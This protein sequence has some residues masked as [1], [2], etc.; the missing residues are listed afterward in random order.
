MKALWF[1]A[2]GVIA[3]SAPT[4]PWPE[5]TGA[6]VV[7]RPVQLL[8]D[9][10]PLV[11]RSFFPSGPM[12][13]SISV[14][15]G[16][17]V[18]TRWM[19]TPPGD[20][21]WML[22]GQPAEPLAVMTCWHHGQPTHLLLRRSEVRKISLSI[23]GQP[24]D[25]V[26]VRGAF[27]G[28][29]EL[30][31]PMTYASGQWRANLA[32]EPGTYEYLFKV[33][34]REMRD[35]SQPD[36]ASNG[37]GG[38]NSLLTVAGPTGEAPAELNPR[39]SADS[40]VSLPGLAPDQSWVA[41]LGNRMWLQGTG[42][43]AATALPALRGYHTLRFMTWRG[44]VM[45]AEVHLPL[46]DGVPVDQPDQLAAGDFHGLS[47]Y[48]LM[49]D[50][51]SNGDTTN[52]HPLNLPDVAPLADW[53]GG[54][55]AGLKSVV[56]SGYFDSLGVTGLW[57]SPLSA[58]PT[59]PW[60]LWDKGGVRSRF[61]GYHGY[62]PVSSTK[63]D[64]HFGDSAQLAQTIDAVHRHHQKIL[65]DYVANHVHV[66]HPVYV[67]N[68]DWATP[69]Y[70]PDGTLNTERWDTHRLTTWF[71]KH[72]AT[73]DLSRY[74]VTDPMA[75]SALYWLQHYNFDGFRHDATKHIDE[76]YWRTLTRRVLRNINRPVYQIGETYGSPALINSYLAAGMLNAQF[77][78]N[79]YDA[80][81]G[82]LIGSEGFGTF[83]R[84][85][86]QSLATYGPHHLMGNISGNQDR[87]RFL[88]L[89]TGEV[90]PD[91]D[92]KLA[93]WTRS[94]NGIT[95]RGLDQ[96]ALLHAINISLPGV[97]CIYYGDEY[98]MPGGNDP[99]NRRMWHSAGLTAD[100]EALRATTAQLFQLR[101]RNMALVYGTTHLS[102]PTTGVLVVRRSYLG[103]TVY[104]VINNSN[105]AHD[106]AD[107]GIPSG[108]TTLLHSRLRTDGTILP[109]QFCI[110][111]P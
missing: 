89:A 101:K 108:L 40:G 15:A 87:P 23:A 85:A 76:L 3:C 102:E 86:E 41:L 99:D 84:V 80:A 69:L 11:A 26:A 9:S 14:P 47:L 73:L 29:N 56:E 46:K 75:D 49:V 95:P 4:P 58:Q 44:D 17:Q 74:D 57:L 105:Q 98:G 42:A 94:I 36:S 18:A 6:V 5:G 20:T 28:W 67:N 78:F 68:P 16:M 71:D 107:V 39:W 81:V 12:P 51:F 91:E 100:Q 70:L 13:D 82:A 72:L 19:N 31:T 62:W 110:L 32:L 55:L 54:D 21:L 90:R 2:V 53:M 30:A 59:G 66:E 52:D 60:G 77:D 96:V 111:A 93:G 50:R 83:I 79:L 8:P 48:F 61:S 103:Q 64:P 45:G 25:A 1:L 27:N 104:V 22:T 65:L 92:S 24:D 43:L 37:M 33:N 88:S 7:Y 34:G 38:Y 109:Q 63:L 35:P 106:L 97:P 10:T